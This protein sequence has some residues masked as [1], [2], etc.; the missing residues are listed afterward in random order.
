MQDR[1]ILEKDELEDNYMGL[2]YSATS[3]FMLASSQSKMENVV[4]LRDHHRS[5]ADIINYS[6]KFFYEDTLRVA[7]KYENLKSILNEPA[8]RWIDVKGKCVRPETGS[9]YNDKEAEQVVK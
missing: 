5:H 2:S 8:V 3:L 4:V 9:S 7:T 6:N 1:H